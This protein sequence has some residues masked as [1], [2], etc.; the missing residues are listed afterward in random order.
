MYKAKRL[1]TLA[2]V[3][4]PIFLRLPSLVEPYWYGDEGIYSAVASE[5]TQGEL[6]YRD[7]WDH[8]PPGIYLVY[9]GTQQFG[10]QQLFVLKFINL[11]LGA[12]AVYLALKLF[13]E[14]IR[15]LN[16]DTHESKDKP[17][18]RATLLAKAILGITLAV[19]L[20]ST[21]LEGNIFNAENVFICTTAAA[22]LLY[23]RWRPNWSLQRLRTQFLRAAAIGLIAGI[24]LY[25][26]LHPLLDLG[27]LLFLMLFDRYMQL[28]GSYKVHSIIKA[29]APLAIVVLA[30]FSPLILTG[31]YYALIGN[32]S[33][34]WEA[35]VTY[36]FGYS[37]TFQSTSL[38]LLFLPDTFGVKTVLLGLAALGLWFM[39][40]RK[41]LNPVMGFTILWVLAAFFGALISSRPYA[42]YLLQALIPATL[43]I[44]L[45]LRTFL[46]IQDERQ[47][48]KLSWTILLIYAGLSLFMKGS[49][50]DWGYLKPSYLPNGYAYISQRLL[51]NDSGRSQW[52]AEF[53]SDAERTWNLA[54]WLK[55]YAGE[56]VFFWG[57]NPWIYKLSGIRNPLK[58]TVYF[59]ID[60]KNSASVL[61]QLEDKKLSYFLVD[62]NFGLRKEFEAYLVNN[63]KPVSTLENRFTLYVRVQDTFA[64]GN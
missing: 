46:F 50:V 41:T 62:S 33:N 59:H 35:V 7:I 8:K 36:N 28:N 32:F 2:A 14:I 5:M 27:A 12:L 19:L 24:G 30:A 15:A 48:L 23:L 38:G 39:Q 56:E 52:Y 53:N 16:K 60:D 22:A 43:L 9:A 57:N 6:L 17:L 18:S 55:P 49:K 13:D 26:K 31:V 34:F 54:Q 29:L 47:L 37:G 10:L 25:F 40:T 42:H 51:G 58:Y 4:L 20:G 45:A 1:I 3:L 44:A 11:V 64:Q 63:F 61:Q 21:S